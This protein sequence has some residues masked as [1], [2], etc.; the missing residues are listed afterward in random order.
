MLA[1]AYAT[2]APGSGN[3]AAKDI[4][5]VWEELAHAAG[6]EKASC[7]AARSFAAPRPPAALVE[8]DARHAP[9]RSTPDT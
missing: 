2:G 7:G 4:C 8:G 5:K 3:Q 9:N 6:L 1:N